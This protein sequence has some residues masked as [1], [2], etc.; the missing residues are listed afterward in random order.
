MARS[1]PPYLQIAAALRERIRSGELRPGGRLPSTR[2]LTRDHGVAL[3]TATR[4]LAVLRDEGMVTA[5]PRVGTL[6]AER[7]GEDVA[8]PDRTAAAPFRVRAEPPDRDEVVRTAIGIAD[9]DGL[10]AV[11]MRRVA[12][13]LGVPTMSLYGPVRNKDDLVLAMIDAAF[14]ARPFPDPAPPG[15]RAR[16]EVSARVQWTVYRRH[17]W[18]ARVVSLTRPQALSSLLTVAEWNLGA[19]E[20]LGVDPTTRFDLHLLLCTYVRGMAINLGAEADAEADTGLDAD[21]WAERDPRIQRALAARPHSA[22][23]RVGAYTPD[24]ERLFTLGLAGLLDGIAQMS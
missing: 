20:E 18:L 2:A 12:V 8:A 3:A 21:T 7:A 5:V 14:R 13:G 16:L 23:A 19:L 1:A 9:L 22:I 24:P 4:A 15:W 6:V 10:P 11:S 17:H